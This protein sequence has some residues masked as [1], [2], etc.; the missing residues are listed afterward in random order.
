MVQSICKVPLRYESLWEIYVSEKYSLVIYV[1][2][3]MSVCKLVSLE[4]CMLYAI[5]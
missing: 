3:N 4:N 2:L 5:L 1:E